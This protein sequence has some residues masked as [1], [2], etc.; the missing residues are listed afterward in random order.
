MNELP[1]FL[2]GQRKADADHLRLL[3]I[4]HFVVA[5]LSLI[6]I[7]FLFLHYSFMHV[8]FAN[9]EM[10]KGQSGSPPP[11][12]FFAVFKWFYLVF[13]L[14]LI[15][16]LVANLFS[17]FFIGRRKHRTFS[18]IVAGLNCLQIPFGT[19]LGV[20]TFIVLLRESVSESYENTQR[21]F[22]ELKR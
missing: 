9:P 11:V 3:A 19:T 5:G 12:E 15:G 16:A 4:F 18:L 13:G 7:G 20:F 8:F 21:G 14:M 1:P 10:W 17:G 6:G 2:Q 22:A